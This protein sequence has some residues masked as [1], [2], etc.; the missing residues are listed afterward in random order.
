VNDLRGNGTPQEVK[1]GLK[2][3]LIGITLVAAV[4]CTVGVFFLTSSS[5]TSAQPLVARHGPVA[6]QVAH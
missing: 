1:F 3:K 4:I 5:T 6:T 2:N